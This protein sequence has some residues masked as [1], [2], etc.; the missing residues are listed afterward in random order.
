MRKV[1][2]STLMTL[3]GKY[4]PALGWAFPYDHEDSNKFHG[5]LLENSDGLI[6]GRTT[7]QFFAALWPPRAGVDPYV[8]KIN[9]MAKYVVSDTLKELEWE[10][11]HLLTGSLAESVGK[12]KEQDGQDLVVYGGQTLIRG[13]AEHGLVDEYKFLLHPVVLGKGASFLDGGVRVDLELV[14]S[15]VIA[16]NVLVLTYRPT[17]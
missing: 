10:N 14:D 8:D 4:D 5:D 15:S 11:S 12:L 13:L 2:V 6:L 17:S 3:D 7:Y 16:S 9:S 1:I